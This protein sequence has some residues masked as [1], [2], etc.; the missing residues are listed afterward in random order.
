MTD[1]FALGVER[2][3]AAT[4]ARAALDQHYAGKMPDRITV[5]TLNDQIRHNMAAARLHFE[6]AQV[7]A[8]YDLRSSVDVAPGS[9]S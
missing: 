2:F 1:H 9:K 7:Q 4:D 5:A 6:A 3:A 8:I